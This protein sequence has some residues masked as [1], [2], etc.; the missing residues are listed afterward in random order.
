MTRFLPV[1]WIRLTIVLWKA[2]IQRRF[3][4]LLFEEIFFVQ[5]EYDRRVGKPFAV[6]RRIKQA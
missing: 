4:Y 1:L 2:D 6:A 3:L 5:E